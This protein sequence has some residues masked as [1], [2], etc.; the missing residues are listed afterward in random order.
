V[1]RAVRCAPAARDRGDPLFGSAAPAQRWLLIEHPGPW[2]R[3]A[4]TASPALAEVAAR[5]TAAGIRTVLIRRPR[6]SHTGHPPASDAD[7]APGARAWAYVDSRPGSEGVWW[8]QFDD[9]RELLTAPLPP[10]GEP[11]VEPIHLVCAHGRHDTCCAVEGRPVAAALDA[12]RPGSTWECSHVGGDRFAPNLILLPHGLYYGALDVPAAL[13]VAAAYRAA[14]VVPEYLRG[15]SVFAPAIQAAQHF[16]RAR[17]G[18]HRLDAFAPLALAQLGDD[19]FRIALAGATV[20]LRTSWSKLAMLTCAA[21][22][23]EAA[24]IFDLLTLTPTT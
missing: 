7:R 6:Q 16:A 2:P 24:R 19:T 11:V 21:G 10:H 22:R 8:S 4:F 20:V 18:D 15:R 9:E 17:S 13:R 3:R 23:P 14:E 5:A 1:T 12:D